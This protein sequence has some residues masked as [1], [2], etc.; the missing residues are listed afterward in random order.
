MSAN[1]DITKA[2]KKDVLLIPQEA[3][4]YDDGKSVVLIK[5]SSKKGFH[6]SNIATGAKQ[7]GSLEVISG[8]ESG[9]IILAKEAVLNQPETKRSSSFFRR[10]GSSRQGRQR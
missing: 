5:D 4:Q 6:E 7:N 10:P 8:V 2:L 1:V 9:D 3:I